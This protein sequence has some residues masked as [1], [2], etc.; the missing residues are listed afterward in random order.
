MSRAAGVALI[1]AAAALEEEAT[2]AAGRWTLRF[3]HSPL[4]SESRAF[5]QHAGSKRLK[6]LGST[7]RVR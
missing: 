4:S 5:G 7:M 6:S 2:I 3:S 1:G